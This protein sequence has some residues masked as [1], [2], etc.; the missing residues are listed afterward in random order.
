[1]MVCAS[2]VHGAWKELQALFIKDCSSAYYV[3]CFAHRL[4]LSLVA[5]AKDVHDVWLFYSKLSSIVNVVCESAKCHSEIK[6]ARE[7]EIANLLVQGELK[8]GIGANQ[9]YT[10]QRPGA[11]IWSS[12]LAAFTRPINLYGVI[13]TII[14]RIFKAMRSFEFL[15]ILFL[16]N[17]VMGITDILCPAL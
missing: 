13:C 5:A 8:T 3:H 6:S 15:F 2:D 12:H 4:Q 17:Q 9:N 16:M 10:L 1:M 14:E 7:I 11:T